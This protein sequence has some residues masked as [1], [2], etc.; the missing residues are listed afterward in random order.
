MATTQGSNSNT[1]GNNQT[2]ITAINLK[3][4]VKNAAGVPVT[5]VYKLAKKTS[6]QLSVSY[7]PANAP[8][9]AMTFT[10]SNSSIAQVS[11]TGKITT[12]NKAGVAQI[13]VTSASGVTKSFYVQVMSGKV[14]SIKIKVASKT[15]KLN[16]KVKLKTVLKK[17]KKASNKIVWKSSNSAIAK[18]SSSGVLTARKKGKVK[19][20]AV[21]A[22][23]SGKKASV[24]LKIK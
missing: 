5:S 6:M 1:N 8:Y 19:I 23:G 24:V 4:N 21:V 15:L 13:T 3:A 22:D 18:M 14:T 10:S 7:V 11:A 12:G 2:A 17:K 16:K 9:E 20:T